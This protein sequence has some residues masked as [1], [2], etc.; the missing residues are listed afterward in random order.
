MPQKNQPHDRQEIFVAG[1]VGIGPQGIRRAPEPLFNGFECSSWA[2]RGFCSEML[3]HGNQLFLRWDGQQGFNA[4]GHQAGGA[5]FR[6]RSIIYQTP[7]R[8]C[9]SSTFS[10]LPGESSRGLQ[11]S[12]LSRRSATICY[13]PPLLT[14][15]RLMVRAFPASSDHSI[16]EPLGFPLLVFRNHITRHDQVSIILALPLAKLGHQPERA[17]LVDSC[18]SMGRTRGRTPSLKRTES[19]AIGHFPH[20]RRLP[21]PSIIQYSLPSP[22]A[23]RQWPWL[24]NIMLIL[25][26]PKHGPQEI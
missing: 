21:W 7:L 16:P 8:S 12:T 26:L 9:M 19:Y 17:G 11:R 1:I 3:F 22:V 6:P 23:L 25:I 13:Q 2:M 4:R 14:E 5:Y 18:I 10:D 24:G 20:N 15:L